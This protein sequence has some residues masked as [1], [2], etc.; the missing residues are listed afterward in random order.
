MT[1]KSDGI[2]F[3]DVIEPSTGVPFESVPITQIHALE[4]HVELAVEASERWQ[5]WSP[6][7]RA[8]LMLALAESIE[9][10]L[11]QLAELEVSLPVRW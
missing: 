2:E 10:R 3:L 11:K 7:D 9:G 1:I 4:Q 5:S 8:R 6:E